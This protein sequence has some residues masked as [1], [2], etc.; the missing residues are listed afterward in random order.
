MI[1][2]AIARAL[3]KLVNPEHPGVP[4]RPSPA[5]SLP[6]GLPPL[7]D[8]A[9]SDAP[10][11]FAQARARDAAMVPFRCVSCGDP[12]G[13]TCAR[14]GVRVCAVHA[15]AHAAAAHEG[16]QEPESS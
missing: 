13:D 12:T 5:S 14:C 3:R 1:R 2:E 4:G 11:L 10:S 9:L 8:Q 6:S 7:M 16:N 15:G